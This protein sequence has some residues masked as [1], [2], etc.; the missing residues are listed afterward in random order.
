MQLL[1]RAIEHTVHVVTD[2]S[3]LLQPVL[4]CGT[5]HDLQADGGGDGNVGGTVLL[6]DEAGVHSLHRIGQEDRTT[7]PTYAL[8]QYVGLYRAH[9]LFSVWQ[10]GNTPGLLE[11][12]E[13][14]GPTDDVTS[15]GVGSVVLARVDCEVL[16]VIAAK[17]LVRAGWLVIDNAFSV[18]ASCPHS[19]HK[20]G[21]FVRT[22]LPTNGCVQ[23]V[24][25]YFTQL[26]ASLH[27]ARRSKRAA[28]SLNMPAG[29][30]L[31]FPDTSKAHKPNSKGRR[32]CV[33]FF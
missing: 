12:T 11:A 9:T 6:A 13:S 19:W 26:G 18:V 31:A 24:S 15:E 3:Q 5:E 14:V 33:L 32:F 1:Q 10:T 7:L 30:I 2:T 23:Y 22:I 27:A 25:L 4:H 21:H 28:C 8:S 29:N 20:A 17:V 16:A